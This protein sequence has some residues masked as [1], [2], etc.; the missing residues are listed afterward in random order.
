MR[1]ETVVLPASM[2]EI[3][4]I[5]RIFLRSGWLMLAFA[6][7]KRKSLV[8]VAFADQVKVLH[9]KI[10][11]LK[12]FPLKLFHVKTIK[13]A[14]VEEVF[15]QAGITLRNNLGQEVMQVNR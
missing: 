4:P 3:M 15:T 6:I 7:G 2:C 14:V 10:I 5:L 9:I 13:A 1:S 12:I 8:R 11:Q